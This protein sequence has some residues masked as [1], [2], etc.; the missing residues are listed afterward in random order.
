MKNLNPPKTQMHTYAKWKTG[1]YY[2]ASA[3][4]IALLLLLT[5]WELFLAPL[6]PNGSWLVLK[7]VPLCFALPGILKQRLYTYRWASMLVL[8]YLAEG[9]VRG[10]SDA[11]ALSRQLAWAETALS[12]VFFGSVLVYIRTRLRLYQH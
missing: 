4:L 12:V 1:A 9:T 5:A 2:S 7:V 8:L 10:M 11:L 6:R 3:S